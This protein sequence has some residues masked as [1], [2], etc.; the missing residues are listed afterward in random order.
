LPQLEYAGRPRVRRLAG[1]GYG[2]TGSLRQEN[3]HTQAT[4]AV[5]AGVTCRS[6][7]SGASAEC[8]YVNHRHRRFR[9]LLL[10]PVLYGVAIEYG[11][12]GEGIPH[13]PV[14]QAIEVE[15]DVVLPVEGP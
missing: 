5:L 13:R 11:S 9:G 14:F 12:F 3:N 10:V 6:W 2:A 1:L 15:V 8:D 4:S 7:R